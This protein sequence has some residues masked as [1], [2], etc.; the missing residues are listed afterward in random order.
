MKKNRT[1]RAFVIA[2]LLCSLVAGM[3]PATVSAATKNGWVK[4]TNGYC[5]Y[6]KGKKVKNQLKKIKGKTYYLGSDG[7]RKTEWYTVKT[8]SKGKTVYKAMKFDSKGVY[9][10]KSQT[11]NTKMI[12]KADAV[13]RSQKINTGVKTEKEKEEAL[14]KLFNTTKKY[15]YGRVIGLNNRTF[16]KSKVANSAYTMMSKKK[17]NCYYYASAFAVLAKRA[18]GLPVRVCWGT[19]TIFNK[20]R[21]QEHAWVEIKLADGKWHV[22]DPNGA[23][24]STRKDVGTYAQKVSSV[25]SVYKAVKNSE[26]N[27]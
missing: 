18:T 23:R 11:I 26:L 25:K 3:I 2:V 12:Q 20:K 22:Y 27:L 5:Y 17:G 15:N 24:F 19:S 16:N 7:I 4:E 13:I 9:T 14:K 21:V 8:T 10:G 6:E 1:Y